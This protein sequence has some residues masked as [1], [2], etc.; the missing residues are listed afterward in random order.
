MK[1]LSRL[2]ILAFFVLSCMTWIGCEQKTVT[3][4]DLSE[5]EA[6]NRI[7]NVLTTFVAGQDPCSELGSIERYLNTIREKSPEKATQIENGFAELQTMRVGS[8]A[9]KKKAQEILDQME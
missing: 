8:A 5:Q 6:C 4:P 1:K 9:I 3:I 2:F 7:K